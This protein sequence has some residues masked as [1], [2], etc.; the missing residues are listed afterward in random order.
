MLN[1]IEMVQ[2]S[3]MFIRLGHAK[4]ETTLGT[5]THATEKMAETIS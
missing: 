2:I 4:L 1:L 5:Y 3:R